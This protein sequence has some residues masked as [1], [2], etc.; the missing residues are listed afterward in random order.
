MRLSILF[1]VIS[2]VLII[3]SFILSYVFGEFSF[4]PFIFILFPCC[5]YGERS[6]VRRREIMQSRTESRGRSNENGERINID[7]L[8]ILGEIDVVRKCQI[9][10]NEIK[11]ENLRFCPY[12]GAKIAS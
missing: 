6:Q 12:C 4:F 9:C 3:I 2:I 10:G 7:D 11:E 1:I 8:E 5:A